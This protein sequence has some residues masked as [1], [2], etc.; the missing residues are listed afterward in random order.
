MDTSSPLRPCKS[1]RWI[2]GAPKACVI[3][4]SLGYPVIHNSSDK[5]L[6]LM[7]P[8][9]CIAQT[10]ELYSLL[11]E[12]FDRRITAQQVARIIPAMDIG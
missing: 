2:K 6:A 7:N 3:I 8:E 9:R 5:I 4:I 10:I 11:L 1:I 12:F